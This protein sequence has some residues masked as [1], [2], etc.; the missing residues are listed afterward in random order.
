MGA[1]S[2]HNS[3]RW[4]I[5]GCGAVTEVK[6]GPALYKTE[7][8]SVSGVYSRQQSKAQDYA[9]RHN[10]ETVFDSI[11]ALINSADVDAVYIATPPDS[12]KDLTVQVAAAGKP[13]C[14]EKPMAL[15]SLE[16][17]AMLD[18]FAAAK[19]PLFVAY[20]RRSLPRFAQVQTWLAEDAI[21]DVRQV[22][23][24]FCKPANELDLSK[25]YNW[26]TD[27]KIAPGGYFDDLAS[28]GINLI[29]HL[30]GDIEQITGLQ[31]N[32]QQLYTA[33][34]AVAACWRHNNGIMGS[35]NWN[36]GASDRRDRVELTGS[37]GR[38]EFSVFGD[39]PVHM[40]QGDKQQSLF[41]ENPPHIQQY[42]AENMLAHL[43]QLRQHPSQ[44]KSARDTC[45]V[46]EEIFRS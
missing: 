46:M 28:H 26:R 19:Q 39:E 36:F 37:K 29:Q 14:V 43:Q 31:G 30:L 18:A 10:I 25:D 34:D 9:R 16:C 32:Q 38:I 41:I 2:T 7:G 42:H 44:G 4:G 1:T 24:Q 23:W 8:S 45:W 12:H 22:H 27:S 40:F 3:I 35:G 6:S 11:D 21:G 20:Y 5:I 33:A 17:D 13:C 15:N